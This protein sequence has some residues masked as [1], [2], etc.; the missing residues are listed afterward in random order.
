[1]TERE[2]ENAGFGI[3]RSCGCCGKEF[4]ATFGW[5]YKRNKKFKGKT[6]VAYYCKWSCMR[7]DEC[8]GRSKEYSI[9]K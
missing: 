8:N 3:K 6:K 1:M 5:V 7:K 4:Y 2:L 9:L